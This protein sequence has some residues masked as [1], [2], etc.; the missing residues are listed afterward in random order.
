MKSLLPGVDLVVVF[1]D[2]V[3]GRVVDSLSRG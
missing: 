2:V 1:V 3:D